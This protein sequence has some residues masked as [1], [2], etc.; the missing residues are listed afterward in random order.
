MP[1]KEAKYKLINTI[2]RILGLEH[3]G[4]TSEKGW[5]RKACE[6][7]GCT[8]IP[9]LRCSEAFDVINMELTKRFLNDASDSESTTTPPRD[10]AL[11]RPAK[12]KRSPD[13]LD[14]E[15]VM[16]KFI[17]LNQP[18]QPVQMF[19]RVGHVYELIT[20][21]ELGAIKCLLHIARSSPPR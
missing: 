1:P 7:L 6:D 14:D 3:P 17:L 21:D 15:R 16:R 11:E 9:D 19:W 4:A 20:Y 12:R 18:N 10:R 13:E 2:N 5:I 8:C